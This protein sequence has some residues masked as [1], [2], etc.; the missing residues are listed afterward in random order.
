M[1]TKKQLESEG[2]LIITLDSGSVNAT[3]LKLNRSVT[4]R[5]WK[6]IRKIIG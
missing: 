1:K 3:N 2:W 5:T 6:T 4:R